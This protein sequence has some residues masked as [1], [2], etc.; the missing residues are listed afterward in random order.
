[1]IKQKQGNV[2]LSVALLGV[3]KSF[4]IFTGKHLWQ[5]LLIDKV[6]HHFKNAPGGCFSNLN[7][8]TCLAQKLKCGITNPCSSLIGYAQA[9]TTAA[10][11]IE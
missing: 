4:A 7:C 6:E 2:M 9:F 1:M 3:Y 8:W 11:L 10:M 5:S